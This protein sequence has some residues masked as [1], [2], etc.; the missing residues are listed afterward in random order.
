M[1]QRIA[2][3]LVVGTHASGKSTLARGLRA[4][5]WQA[6]AFALEHSS[7]PRIWRRKAPDVLI[8]LYCSY[9]TLVR[10][11]GVTW[12]KERWR[13]QVYALGDAWAHADIRMQTDFF[14]PEEL[15]ER[16]VHRLCSLGVPKAAPD[17]VDSGPPCYT[18]GEEGGTGSSRRRG[19]QEETPD[20]Q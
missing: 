10:R 7:S 17:G 5:G 11:R 15:I 2:K 9:E 20:D 3:I 1:S 6:S 8:A 19:R 16:V 13:R 18:G 14:R 4:A 12:P